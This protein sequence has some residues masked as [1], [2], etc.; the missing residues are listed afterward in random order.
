MIRATLA[1]IRIPAFGNLAFAYLVNE[2][3]NWLGEIA[4]A[5]LVFDAT[6]STLATAG[7]FIA[8]QALPALAAPPLVAR[9]ERIPVGSV[10]PCLYLGEAA[11]FAVLAAVAHSFALGGLLAIAAIDGLLG[12]SARALTRGTVVDLLGPHD[13]LREGNAVLNLAFTTAA[14]VGPALAGLVVAGVGPRG[15]L[16]ADAGSFAGAALVVALARGLPAARR[17]ARG[18]RWGIR[19]AI[20]HVRAR[21]ELRVLLGAQ[22]IALVFFAVVIPIEVAFA[23]QTLDSGNVGY[24]ALLASWGAGMVAGGLAFAAIRRRSLAMLLA[25]STAA[26]GFA[27]LLTAV[28]PTLAVACLASVIGGAGNGLQ[29]VGVVTAVQELTGEGYQMRVNSLLDSISRAAPGVGFA[30]GGIVAAVVDPRASYAV[31]GIGVLAVLAISAAKLRG[32]GWVGAAPAPARLGSR[33]TVRRE[34][35]RK[36]A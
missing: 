1:P 27:Y 14:A 29:F 23:K 35:G 4:L 31:A 9:I 19:A 18:E 20:A 15:A 16:L 36:A 13:L 30:I 17:L 33:P 8:M 26:I 22:G 21:P 3:G 11:A 10:L 6:H 32:T 25:A 24:G 2:L 5:V 7:L 28:S 34:A 12:A